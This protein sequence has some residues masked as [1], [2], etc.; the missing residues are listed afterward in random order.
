MKD[1]FIWKTIGHQRQKIFLEKSI[2]K[3]AVSQARRI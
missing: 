1:K 3:D 2:I